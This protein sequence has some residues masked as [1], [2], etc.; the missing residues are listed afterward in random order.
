MPWVLR[1]HVHVCVGVVILPLRL[2]GV[3]A[4]PHQAAESILVVDHGVDKRPTK[5]I[6][7]GHRQAKSLFHVAAVCPVTI[8]HDPTNDAVHGA[9]DE[10]VLGTLA[11][12]VQAQHGHCQD[13]STHQ[14][15]HANPASIN[16]PAQHIASKLPGRTPQGFTSVHSVVP[17]GVPLRLPEGPSENLY[18]GRCGLLVVHGLADLRGVHAT[19][20]L[21]PDHAIGLALA[22]G[23]LGADVVAEW[24]LH[25]LVIGHGIFALIL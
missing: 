8:K 10:A 3:T 4:C 16:E 13:R 11:R 20:L 9:H 25:C 1:H 6:Q 23:L 15:S 18:I 5:L 14:A 2:G 21:R 7:G 19:C 24:A 22:E 17:I 12:P